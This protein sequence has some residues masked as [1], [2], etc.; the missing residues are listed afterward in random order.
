MPILYICI[1]RSFNAFQEIIL[2]KKILIKCR[3]RFSYTKVSILFIEILI[4]LEF[5]HEVLA[6]KGVLHTSV[7][8][9]LI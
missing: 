2:P 8:T 9:N 5:T 7:G 1:F 4:E 6:I 3:N